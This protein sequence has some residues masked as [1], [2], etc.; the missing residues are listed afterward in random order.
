[1]NKIKSYFTIGVFSLLVFVLPAVASA[2]WQGRNDDYWNG[3]N[4]RNIHGTIHSLED[5]AREFDR[6]VNRVD[7]R[8]DDRRWDRYDRYDRLDT[9]ASRFKNAAE[10]LEDEFG[11]GR[12]LNNSR[13]EA[14]R[15][16]DLGSQIDQVVYN[17]RGRRGGNVQ[18]L[19][20]EWRQIDTD[21]RA[22]A[23]VYGLNYTSRN[24][25]WHNRIGFPL[26]Y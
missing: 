25:G 2:Q 16:L 11:R 26:P 10:N 13:D 19:E 8:R 7:N 6:Q 22:L 17:S 12:N 5:R 1:M 14:R 9:L 24:G 15:V 23:N 21:L 18:Y 3:R 4:G 20:A